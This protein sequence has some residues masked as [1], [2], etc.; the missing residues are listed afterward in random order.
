MTLFASNDDNDMQPHG[1]F[2]ASYEQ[3]Y[4]N[5]LSQSSLPP[6]D[7]A[8]IRSDFNSTIHYYTWPY[9]MPVAD[10]TAF[11]PIPP[12]ARAGGAE[13]VHMCDAGGKSVM[14]VLV[15]YTSWGGT[16]KNGVVILK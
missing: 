16:T 1:D 11:I 14:Y 3:Y 6:Y 12:Q 10:S 9:L 15:K 5:Y 7:I 2:N 8:G 4:Y 13:E